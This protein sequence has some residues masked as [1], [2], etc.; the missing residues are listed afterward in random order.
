MYEGLAQRLVRRAVSAAI[1]QPEEE[2]L[3]LYAYQL[4]LAGAFS[5]GSLLLL[6]FFFNAFWGSLAYMAFYI[7]LRMFAG[8]Y[9]EG[10]YL[11]CYISSIASYFLIVLV[12]PV[13]A[14]HLP[15]WAVMLIVAASVVVVFLRAPVADPNKP[16]DQRET[17]LFRR[18]ARGIALFEAAII[19][20]MAVLDVNRAFLLF[21]TASILTVAVLLLKPE[22]KQGDEA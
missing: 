5:W 12:C 17:F 20:A 10:S 7:P 8:G 4:M 11:K 21:A 6:G 3:Y 15:L 22:R 9:H 1:I 14:R 13:A 2:E 18:R 19:V 16:L